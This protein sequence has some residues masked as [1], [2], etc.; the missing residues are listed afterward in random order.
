MSSQNFIF[1]PPPPPPPIAEPQSY[2]NNFQLQDQQHTAFHGFG[3]G[4]SRGGTGQRSGRGR[5]AAFR[6]SRGG[7]GRGGHDFGGISKPYGVSKVSNSGYNSQRASCPVNNGHPLANYPQ[8]Q[9]T[10]QG[11]H[12]Y[13][14]QNYPISP[15]YGPGVISHTSQVQPFMTPFSSHEQRSGSIPNQYSMHGEYY[16]RSDTT[17]D[18][19]AQALSGVGS[20]KIRPFIRMGFDNGSNSHS[21]QYPM[22][23]LQGGHNYETLRYQ[24]SGKSFIS[25]PTGDSRKPM[26]TEAFGSTDSAMSMPMAPPPV[27]SFGVALPGEPFQANEKVRRYRKKARK[28]NQLG[29]TPKTEEHESSSE[30]DVD[31]ESKLAAMHPSGAKPALEQ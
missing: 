17:S 21:R 5:E 4:K 26:P 15:G 10:K 7:R 27:P 31:E 9:Y 30:E 24:H 1:P 19:R 29:L 25:S 12:G 6:G 3:N 11:H 20:Y 18:V 28:H 22:Q 2:S 16:P 23:S 8:A 13:E 14:G